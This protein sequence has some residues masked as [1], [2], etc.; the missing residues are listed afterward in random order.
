LRTP[1]HYIAATA[2]CF[3]SSLLQSLRLPASDATARTHNVDLCLRSIARRVGPPALFGVTARD[4]VAGHRQKTLALLWAI[5]MQFQL[6]RLVDAAALEREC[7]RLRA[8]PATV[9]AGT[10]TPDQVPG[11]SAAVGVRG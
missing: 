11:E 10:P 6:P 3:F 2:A 9:A 5:V 1:E 7:T 4:I 8:L